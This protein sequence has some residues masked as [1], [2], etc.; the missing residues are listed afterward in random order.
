M[1]K[2]RQPKAVP[3]DPVTFAEWRKPEHAHKLVTRGELLFFLDQ[4][5]TFLANQRPLR[6][7]SIWLGDQVLRY[8]NWVVARRR[9]RLDAATRA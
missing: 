8:Q 5:A 9:A 2:H 1:V 6:R 4:Q 7:L 3:A